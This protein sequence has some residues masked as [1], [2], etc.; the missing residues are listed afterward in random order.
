MLIISYRL[1]QLLAL[2]RRSRGGQS[3]FR[4]APGPR[5]SIFFRNLNGVIDL[6]AEVSDRAL[7]RRQLR[8]AVGLG[9]AMVDLRDGPRLSL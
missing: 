1:V 2:F 4:S 8:W 6:N 7:D 5:T 3:S 9:R